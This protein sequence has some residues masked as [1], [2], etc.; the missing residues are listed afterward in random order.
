MSTDMESDALRVTTPVPVTVK[1]WPD[2]PA[3]L[4]A[5]RNTVLRTVLLSA[6]GDGTSYQISDYEPK[7]VRLVVIP[8]DAACVI[9][10]SV[11]STS[12]DTSIA[13]TKPSSGGAV[14]PTGIQPYEFYGPD[15]LWLNRLA[16]DTRVTIIKEFCQ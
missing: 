15:A 1:N 8:L 12:P 11:P 14:L 16:T 10:D 13:G 4:P 3:K 7:R 2:P 9:M 5:V 6:T